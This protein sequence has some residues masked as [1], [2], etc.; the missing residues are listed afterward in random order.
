M[1][2][3]DLRVPEVIWRVISGPVWE[4]PGGSILGSILGRFWGNLGPILDPILGNLIKTVELPSF[5]RR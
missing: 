4:G 1:T 3:A 2:E 5:G